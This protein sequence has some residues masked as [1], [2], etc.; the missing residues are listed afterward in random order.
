[1]PIQITKSGIVLF[2]AS[3]YL[4]QIQ[5][6]FAINHCV[7]LSKFF[8]RKLL[9]FLRNKLTRAS[10]FEDRYKVG[11][12]NATGYTTDDE[13]IVG[14]IHFLLNDEKLFNFI[15]KITGCKKI[16]CFNGRVYSK[17]PNQEQYDMWHDDL[18]QNRMVAISV[19]LSPEPFS[20]GMLQIRNSKSKQ[21]L[22]EAANIDFGGAIIFRIA[23]YLEHRVT[24]VKGKTIR[25]VLT[26]WFRS[27]PIYKLITRSR[28]KTLERVTI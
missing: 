8:D 18:A 28:K 22:C 19:N 20:G 2:E 13:T 15:Q 10:F 26:G 11:N 7:T 1:M 16:G 4:E 5:N 24:R 23:P 25:T 14:L 12:N 9:Q 21:I 3:K 27:K 17:V 6:E